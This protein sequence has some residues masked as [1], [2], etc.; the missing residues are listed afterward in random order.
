MHFVVA[1]LGHTSKAEEVDAVGALLCR[2]MAE[3]SPFA[4]GCYFW[5]TVT[6]FQTAWQ[7]SNAYLLRRGA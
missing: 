2:C 6:L 3:K 1:W 4:L 5:K 7:G